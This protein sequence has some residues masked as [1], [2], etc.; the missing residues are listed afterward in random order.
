MSRQ[1]EI[2]GKCRRY[3]VIYRCGACDWKKEKK[4]IRKFAAGWKEIAMIFSLPFHIL[5]ICID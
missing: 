2:E 4:K 5:F 3:S 1:H